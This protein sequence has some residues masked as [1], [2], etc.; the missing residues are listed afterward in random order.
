MLCCV[1]S[2]YIVLFLYVV[3]SCAVLFYI[4]LDRLALCC[5]VLCFVALYC[6]VSYLL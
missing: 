4:G 2:C 3:L 6:M 5:I 1:V